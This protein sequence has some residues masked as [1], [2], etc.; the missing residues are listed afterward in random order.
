MAA[1]IPIPLEIENAGLRLEIAQLREENAS[2]RQEFN[3]LADLV[4]RRFLE[5]N[6]RLKSLEGGRKVESGKVFAHLEVL[7]KWLHEHEDTRKGL[8]YEEA[9]R[10]INVSHV[11]ICQMKAAIDKDGRM[12]VDRATTGRHRMRIVLA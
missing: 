7:Y 4:G 10:L 11:R 8:T 5:V 2:L 3:D 12:K 6:K 1:A 9:A